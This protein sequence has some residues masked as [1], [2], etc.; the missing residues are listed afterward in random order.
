MFTG[1]IVPALV[2][3]LGW[4]NWRGGILYG[5]SLRII[6]T[7]HSTFCVNSLAHWAG[8]QPFNDR[9]SPRNHIFTAIITLG[10]GY[11]DFHHK[12]PSDYRNGIEWYQIDPTK[13]II[14]IWKQLGLA[15]NLKKF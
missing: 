2:T 9:N 10:E 3:G 6:I 4:G 13:W 1:F 14:W 11:H 7:W 5:G 12:F 15:S 8:E